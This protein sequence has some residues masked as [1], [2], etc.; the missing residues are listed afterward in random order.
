M[1]WGGGAERKGAKCG[2]ALAWAIPMGHRG[3]DDPMKADP[4]AS[5]YPR[6]EELAFSSILSLQG[7]ISR[8]Q[9]ALKIS[10]FHFDAENEYEWATWQK[11]GVE[12]NISV[13]HLDWDEEAEK[14]IPRL[15]TFS[16]LFILSSDCPFMDDDGRVLKEVVEKFSAPMARALK[17]TI[18]HEGREGAVWGGN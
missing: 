9:K 11:N 18:R 13:E 2:E 17:T 15:R 16:L 8:V 12:I 7:V 6:I 1:S 3:Y 14:E 4:T 10:D 5:P